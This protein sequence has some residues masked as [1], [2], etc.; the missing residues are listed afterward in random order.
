M[1]YLGVGAVL[2]FLASAVEVRDLALLVGGDELGGEGQAD[3]FP[4]LGGADGCRCAAPLRFDVGVGGALVPHTLA[5]GEAV[6]HRGV[7]VLAVNQQ[8]V[9]RGGHA[10]FGEFYPV[11]V[12]VA[13][14][15]ICHGAVFLV[16]LGVC[17][18]GKVVAH[19]GAGDGSG[20]GGARRGGVGQ[21]VARQVNVAESG[22]A[23]V[24]EQGLVEGGSRAVG[25]RAPAE[26]VASGHVAVAAGEVDGR[27]ALVGNL[28][29]IVLLAL[30]KDGIGVEVGHVHL[31]AAE[32]G[33]STID[34]VAVLALIHPAVGAPDGRRHVLMREA[35]DV[36]VV[37]GLSE[38][39]IVVGPDGIE[40]GGGDGGDARRGVGGLLLVDALVG[41]A[42]DAACGIAEVAVGEAVL[43]VLLYLVALG[44]AGRYVARRAELRL[45]GI[46]LG[47]RLGEGAVGIGGIERVG[48]S[49]ADLPVVVALVE[50]EAVE[51]V[52]QGA[53]V[54][55]LGIQGAGLAVGVVAGGHDV[56]GCRGVVEPR[57]AVHIAVQEEVG[58]HYLPLAGGGGIAEDG[59]HLRCTVR[60]T[61][62][63][64]LHPAV[65]HVALALVGYASRGERAGDAEVIDIAA[66]VAEER[67][68]EAADGV[69][70]AVEHAAEALAVAG[71]GGPSGGTAWRTLVGTQDELQILAALE[72][73]GRVVQRHM[74]VEFAADDGLRLAIFEGELLVAEV[75]ELA[76]EVDAA[77]A[78]GGL[79]A[80]SVA[81]GVVVD[82]NLGLVVHVLV[83]D[84][85]VVLLVVHHL[86][87]VVVVAHAEGHGVGVSLA[88][89]RLGVV[90]YPVVVLVPIDGIHVV[91]VALSVVVGVG[92]G[93]VVE[94]LPSGLGDVEGARRDGGDVQA[95]RGTRQHEGR[96]V[97]LAN[98]GHA[99][100]EADMDVD[101]VALGDGRDV[102]A[103]LVALL[104][105]VEVDDGD[106]LL[107]REVVD[108]RLVR[109][110]ER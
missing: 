87:Q 69:A 29:S 89:A 94:D 84:V 7:E 43:H 104:V 48:R 71:D 72:R 47:L 76:E 31:L 11:A 53:V 41:R 28:G 56:A 38:E 15:L 22:D 52:G 108:V 79:G 17:R 36:V 57:I 46:P 9:A 86:L 23:V 97:Q 67:V 42:G 109:H 96:R 25:H 80:G 21:Q 59:I 60:Q 34:A 58:V 110:V 19:G 91:G 90:G 33:R 4:S 54:E 74:A 49:L 61:G 62:G 12:D 13:G 99:A 98:L 20:R 85:V 77:L 16:G 6:A 37:Q 51:V 81:H 102:V 82:V 83:V 106:D 55:G 75:D 14:V 103:R 30:C 2:A 39:Q 10:A 26:L 27:H 70:V 44:G 100:L 45:V 64:A 107:L 101:D 93:V 92:M 1:A 78:L 66:E 73:L 8:V 50:V 95:Q 40:V 32:V 88:Q 5:G 63:S 105:L 18:I 24:V 68:V 65:L 3:A 35:V